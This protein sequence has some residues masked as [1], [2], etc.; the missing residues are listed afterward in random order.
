MTDFSKFEIL[1]ENKSTLQETSCY[2]LSPN[3]QYMTNSSL[4]AIN[5]DNVKKDY[6]ESLHLS[7]TPKSNDALYLKKDGN[8]LFVEFKSGTIN[9]S[10]M[11]D[12]RRKIYDSVLIL[13]DILDQGISCMRENLDYILV[14]NEGAFGG[15]TSY[16]ILVENINKNANVELVYGGLN[17]FKGYCFRTVATQPISDFEEFLKNEATQ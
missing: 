11:H 1:E 14:H 13:G 15:P 5:F 9:K 7:E 2:G 8:L 17:A 16:N 6:I 3:K 12:L 4:V 10:I